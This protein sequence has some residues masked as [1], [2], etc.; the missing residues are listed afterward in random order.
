MFMVWDA[1]NFPV[2]VM[3]V[4]TLADPDICEE[5]RIRL[6][7]EL[8]VTRCMWV[9]QPIMA[10]WLGEHP[11]WRIVRWSCDYTWHAKSRT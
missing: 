4:C 11:Q 2:L 5:K 9:A 3:T 10:Q 1:V 7:G 6:D 8:A